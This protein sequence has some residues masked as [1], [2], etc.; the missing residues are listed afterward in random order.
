M[1]NFK[2]QCDNGTTTIIRAR[3]SETAMMLFCKAEGCS[4]EWFSKHCT[5][6]KMREV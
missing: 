6:R 5:V 3:N 2:I 4:T 1:Y